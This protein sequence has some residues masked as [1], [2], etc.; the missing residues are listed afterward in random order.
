MWK[1]VLSSTGYQSLKLAIKNIL[2]LP[3]ISVLAELSFLFKIASSLS[4]YYYSFVDRFS[5]M[6]CI[7]S[8]YYSLTSWSSTLKLST[9]VLTE[10]S[11]S[12]SISISTLIT[13]YLPWTNIVSSIYLVRLCFTSRTCGSSGTYMGSSYI[14]SSPCSAYCKFINDYPSL[15]FFLSFY[16][17]SFYY[18][19]VF[20][21]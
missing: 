9:E 12:L 16:P 15:S 8:S 5:D 2:S 4:I 17:S 1:I 10:N 11:S 3:N 14:G 7:L 21:Y 19:A 20:Y 13:N 18:S 6:S